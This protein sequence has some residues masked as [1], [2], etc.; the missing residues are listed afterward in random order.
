MRQ[1]EHS[2]CHITPTAPQGTTM[3]NNGRSPGSQMAMQGKYSGGDT[4][5]AVPMFFFF[6]FSIFFFTDFV[7]LTSVG[8]TMGQRQVPMPHDLPHEPGS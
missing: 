6:C 2:S 1:H 3:L 5:R 4:S 8:Y 7:H